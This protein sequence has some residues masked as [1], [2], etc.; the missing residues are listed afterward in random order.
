MMQNNGKRVFVEAAMNYLLVV[1]L[2][3][4]GLAIE[5]TDNEDNIIYQN[6]YSDKK[7]INGLDIV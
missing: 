4:K 6:S 5:L 7:E 1:K 3:R 2:F